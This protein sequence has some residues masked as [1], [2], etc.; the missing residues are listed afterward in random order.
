MPPNNK[1]PNQG[2]Q[3]EELVASLETIREITQ[4]GFTEVAEGIRENEERLDNLEKNNILTEQAVARL[5]KFLDGNGQPGIQVTIA[6][7]EKDLERATSEQKALASKID[8]L[9]KKLDEMKGNALE[10]MWDILKPLIVA[11]IASGATA[12]ALGG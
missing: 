1:Q 5:T 12:A 11:A 2:N 9:D 6:K 8:A 7:I 4:V 10:K 3:R